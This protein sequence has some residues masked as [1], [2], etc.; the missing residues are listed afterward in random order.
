MASANY[1]PLRL[2]TRR[3]IAVEKSQIIGS[4]RVQRVLINGVFVLERG[5]GKIA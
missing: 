5:P 2:L 3:T 1:G 4:A